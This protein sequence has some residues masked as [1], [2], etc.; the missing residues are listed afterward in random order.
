MEKLTCPLSIEEGKV[1]GIKM[2]EM[3]QEQLEAFLDGVAK[4]GAKAALA[5]VGLGDDF[6]GNDIMAVRDLLKGFRI[7]KKEAWTI[8]IKGCAR[9]F[10]WMIVLAVAAM[11]LKTQNLTAQL[12][13]QKM[14]QP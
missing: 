10:G 3:T 5:D 1:L 12:L 4:R 2:C 14:V 9:V 6:A 11:L 13:A 7:F 8:T